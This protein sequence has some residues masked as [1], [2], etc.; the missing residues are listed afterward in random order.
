MQVV[1]LSAPA[2]SE[3][4][5]LPHI[6]LEVPSAPAASTNGG[7]TQPGAFWTVFDFH[8]HT[9]KEILAARSPT[10]SC[11]AGSGQRYE[12]TACSSCSIT[13]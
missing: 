12:P 4:L 7:V 9:A 10:G 6:Y 13:T 1:C 8:T 3:V 11:G 2:L 5:R